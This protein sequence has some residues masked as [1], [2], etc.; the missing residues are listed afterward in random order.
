MSQT[1]SDADA[2]KARQAN[3]DAAAAIRMLAVKAAVFIGVPLI[4]ALITVFVVLG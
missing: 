4:A 2:A 1:Q 3:A